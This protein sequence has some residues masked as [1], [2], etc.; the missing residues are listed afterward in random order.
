MLLPYFCAL[1]SWGFGNYWRPKQVLDGN[2]TLLDKAP[3]EKQ[4]S[5]ASEQIPAN[6]VPIR[7]HNCEMPPALEL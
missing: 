6:A 4:T 5:K 3:P 2:W 7:I 1:V